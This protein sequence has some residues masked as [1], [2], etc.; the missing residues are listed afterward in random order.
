MTATTHEKTFDTP[1]WR[2]ERDAKMIAWI[3]QMS[4][5]NWLLDFSNICEFFDDAYDKD[6]PVTNKVIEQVLYACL[7]DYP[8]NSFFQAHSHILTPQV[9]FV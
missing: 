2:A 3:G 4:A 9:S 8:G 6:K 1:E 7:V 5:V